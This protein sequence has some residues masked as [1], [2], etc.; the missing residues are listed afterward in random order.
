MEVLKMETF[1]CLLYGKY[2]YKTLWPSAIDTNFENF[3][4]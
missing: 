3:P 2:Q 1:F 4:V